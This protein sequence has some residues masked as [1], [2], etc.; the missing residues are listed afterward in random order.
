MGRKKKRTGRGTA[1]NIPTGKLDSL[2]RP[3]YVSG[4]AQQKKASQEP[5]GSATDS[6]PKPAGITPGNMPK[7][8]PVATL[9]SVMDKLYPLKGE[10]SD[11]AI[12]KADALIA[13]DGKRPTKSTISHIRSIER[14]HFSQ[15]SVGGTINASSVRELLAMAY[16]QRVDGLDG[17][18]ADEMV[19]RGAARHMVSSP[20]GRYLLVDV[21]GK[22][23]VRSA[24]DLPDN[25]VVYLT[26]K[27]KGVKPSF[28]VV[29]ERADTDCATVIIGK[30]EGSDNECVVTA[31]PGVPSPQRTTIP[32]GKIIE[33]SELSDSGGLTLGRVKEVLGGDNFSVLTAQSEKDIV[34]WDG[35]MD[36]IKDPKVVKLLKEARKNRQ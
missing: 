31:M 33:F 1:R 15:N 6:V 22:S 28:V 14:K 21:G 18:D 23:G 17:N 9:R 36:N 25:T 4:S 35:K 8:H 12:A 16:E 13:P 30:P 27:A 11:E 29:S 19:S 2:G 20:T 32:P 34:A 5:K 24:S 3:I 7:K 10:Y 26:Q